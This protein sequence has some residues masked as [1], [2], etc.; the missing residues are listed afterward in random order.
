MDRVVPPLV[1]AHT[2]GNQLRAAGVL[3]IARKT[4]RARLR[5]LDLKVIRTVEPDD[6][7]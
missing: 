6:A 4:L 3:G 1:P 7:Q 2:E 5:E